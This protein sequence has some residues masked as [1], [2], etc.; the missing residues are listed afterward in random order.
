MSTPTPDPS[1]VISPKVVY[2]A[3]TAVVGTALGAAVTAL[4]PDLFAFLGP[5][6]PVAFAAVTAGG[7]VLAGYLKGDPL[8]R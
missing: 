8:R 3:G 1:K 6:E 7:A 4:T 2:A 5:W